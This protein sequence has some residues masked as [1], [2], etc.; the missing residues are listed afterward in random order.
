MRIGQR[1]GLGFGIIL[2]LMI[3]TA[4]FISLSLNRIGKVQ[5]VVAIH[6]ANIKTFDALKGVTEQ[7]LMTT[8][9]IIN[10][11]N[12]SILDYH[13]ILKA[14]IEKKL[15]EIDWDVYGREIGNLRDDIV[16]SYNRMVKLDNAVQ[17]YLRL[18]KEAS[19][20]IINMDNA[21]N[22]FE[23]DASRITRILADL[24]ERLDTAYTRIITYSKKTEKR[25]WLSIYIVVPVTIIFSII[26][27]F[28]ITRGITKPLKILGMA[29]KKVAEGSYDAKWSIK[30]SVEID[31]LFNAFNSMS[32]KL[33]ESN[34]RLMQS[35]NTIKEQ[36][37]FLDTILTNTK[38]M[39]VVTD[40]ENKVE[41]MNK[42]AL[43][44]LGN[45]IG[46]YCYQSILNRESPCQQ[47]SGKELLRE[48][49]KMEQTVKEKVYDSVIVP[50]IKSTGDISK[51]EIF[52]DIT[53]T[54][55][56]QDELER[57]SVTDK[58][59]GLYNRRYFD[60]ILGKEVSRAKR[61][62]HDLSLLFIDIDKFKHFNDTYGHPEGDK[63]LQ[64][65][66]KLMKEQLRTGIDTI[67]RYGG[68]EFT[69]LLP[70]TS[71]REAIIIADRILK[72]FRD[73][74]FHIPLKDETV[75][76]T[77]SIGI[78]E[79]NTSPNAKALLVNADSAMYEAKKLGGNRVCEYRA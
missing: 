30:S 4:V 41:Y 19:P 73:I 33:N 67:C 43:M 56:F 78:S 55:Q 48:T 38:D 10:N 18:G 20:E 44:E 34:N 76:K 21:I 6:I 53:E 27:A 14:S 66:G 71:S 1:L 54:K 75:Q 26:Y 65:L 2:L 52:R 74:K 25:G 17:M 39:I 36:R 60:D 37:D 59:T 22:V 32:L 15:K 11:R 5:K 31:E 64:R 77:I 8:E 12:L 40:K 9:Y 13:E 47:C 46:K 45:I 7:W 24:K 69:I 42:A 79:F 58:L 62:K 29:T 16:R 63:V 35:Y 50:L 28:F 70:E 61:L 72:D 68:E 57:L 23:A 3:G 49:L 51:M